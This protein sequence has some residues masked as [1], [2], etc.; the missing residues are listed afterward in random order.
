MFEK[1]CP[2]FVPGGNGDW[3]SGQSPLYNCIAHSVQTTL[4]Y[5]W[6]DEDEQYAWPPNIDRKE[7]V[8][9][10]NGTV[11]HAALQLDG[12]HWTSKVGDLADI[13]HVDLQAASGGLNGTPVQALRRVR[14]GKPP[15]LPPLQPPLST[16]VNASGTPF[17]Q[18]QRAAPNS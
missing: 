14:T 17:A 2:N 5:I 13:M 7:T 6:P 9:A 11:C 15:L 8:A 4:T 1:F 10:F 16:L 3:T 12:G 18:L